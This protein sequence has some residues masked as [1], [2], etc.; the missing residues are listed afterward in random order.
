[1]S[2]LSLRRRNAVESRDLRPMSTEPKKPGERSVR[3]LD[4]LPARVAPRATKLVR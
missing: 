3:K 4:T 2:K 1:M